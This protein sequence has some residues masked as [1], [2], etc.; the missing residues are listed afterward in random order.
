MDWVFT[1]DAFSKTRGNL[2]LGNNGM[3]GGCKEK[4]LGRYGAGKFLSF[5]STGT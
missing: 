2:P 5:G 3:F 1:Q 4:N